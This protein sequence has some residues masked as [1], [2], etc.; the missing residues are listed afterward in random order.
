MRSHPRIMRGIAK[1]HRERKTRLPRRSVRNPGK[2]ILGFRWTDSLQIRENNPVVSVPAL[3][4]QKQITGNT[5]KSKRK[6]RG[7]SPFSLISRAAAPEGHFPDRAAAL[8]SVRLFARHLN[9]FLC[10]I[11]FFRGFSRLT[12]NILNIYKSFTHQAIKYII[13]NS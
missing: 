7:V 10:R 3:R 9:R 12:I 1:A 8:F 4:N 13:I 6:R 2:K 11:A 5:R